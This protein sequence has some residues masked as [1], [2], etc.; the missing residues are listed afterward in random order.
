MV[1]HRAE[2]LRAR[3]VVE[4]RRLLVPLVGGQESEQAV[5]IA[6]QLAA[7]HGA[8]VIAL[9]VI[10][11]AADLP[12]AAHMVD[13][14]AEAKQMLAEARAIG[15]LYGVSVVPRTVKARAAGPAI[16]DE[17]RRA[18]TELVVLR[19]PR[20]K[21]YG[22]RARVFGKTVDHVLKHAPCRVMIAATPPES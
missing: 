21:R 14:E 9:R 7:E 1:A 2:R 11:V 10:E 16:V 22:K 3:S 13:E 4:Y 19:A 8:A 5:T 20:K 18:R 17:A 12:L 6:C 15:D